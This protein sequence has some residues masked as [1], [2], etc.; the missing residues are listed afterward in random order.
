MCST[1]YWVDKKITLDY[2]Q[3]SKFYSQLSALI[4]IFLLF[5]V[6]DRVLDAGSSLN[7]E[8]LHLRGGKNKQPNTFYSLCVLPLEYQLLFKSKWWSCK[9][10]MSRD[11]LMDRVKPFWKVMS[12]YP[13][14]YYLEWGSR[15]AYAPMHRIREKSLVSTLQAQL[16]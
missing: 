10:S 15:P 3:W 9:C 1:C 7:M 2:M 6:Q 16:W 4:C 14:V 11:S 13:L 8:A 5:F 12:A